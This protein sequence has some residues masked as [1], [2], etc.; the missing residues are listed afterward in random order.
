MQTL[1]KTAAVPIKRSNAN[2]RACP[3][4][5]AT[6][7]WD[8]P[9]DDDEKP[10]SDLA[11]I[12][13]HAELSGLVHMNVAS[14]TMLDRDARPASSPRRNNSSAS[15]ASEASEASE[16][17]GASDAS[18][19]SCT[20]DASYTSDETQEYEIVAVPAFATLHDWGL[21]GSG[22]ATQRLDIYASPRGPV[23]AGWQALCKDPVLTAL[24]G[25][26]IVAM[27]AALLAALGVRRDRA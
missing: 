21:V 2:A 12:L 14:V 10:K 19:T 3:G 16:A 4:P 18:Y 27:N 1:F 15:Y 25:S 5:R 22:H 11:L 9:K 13:R 17:S 23:G 6:V 8:Y 20:S 24:Y 26:E 7:G